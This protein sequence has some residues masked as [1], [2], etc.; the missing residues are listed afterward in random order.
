[1]SEG[2]GSEVR[3]IERREGERH[4]PF[5]APPARE[6]R[7]PEPAPLPP[8]GDPR[9]PRSWRGLAVVLALVVGLAVAL[10]V[11]FVE[12]IALLE[13]DDEPAATAQPQQVAVAEAP[14][15]FQ[16]TLRDRLPEVPDTLRP[17]SP[18]YDIVVDARVAGPYL[19]TLRLNAPTQDQRNLGAYTFGDS[20]WR[21][22]DSALLNEDGSAAQVELDTPPANIA[23]LRRLQFRDTVTGRVHQGA[24]LSPDAVNALTIINPEGFVPAEDGS[25]LGRVDQLPVGVTQPIYPVV[26]AQAEGAEIVNTVLASD[27]LRRQHINNILLM[28]QTGR[29]DGVDIDYQQVSPALRDAFTTFITELA[30]QL[31][32]DGRGLSVHVPLPR[33]DVSGLNEGAYDLAAL[34]AAADLIK[35]APLVDPSVFAETM[36][37][38]L[39]SVLD[40][41][42][43]EKV[44]LSLS[45]R[46][47]LRSA[48][49]FQQL[50]QRDAL[51]LAST[52]SIREPGPVVSGSRVTLVGDS[53]FQDGGASGLF[54]DQFARMVSFV[55]P[56]TGGNL[57]TVWIENRFSAA[58]KLQAVE[59]FRLGGLDIT[60]VSADGAQANL[61]TAVTIFLETG[62]AQPLRPNPALLTPFWEVDAGELTG[63]GSAGWVVWETPR[64]PG[65]YEARLILSD[66]D[67]RVGH[68]LAVTVEP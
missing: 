41:V 57:V 47:V 60:D 3:R 58:F 7:R 18:I 22:L 32:R 55:Y 50:S 46:S 10:V 64:L 40:R 68:G 1:M 25:L 34:G 63:S 4:S 43:R 27:Q 48:N 20:G 59:A 23:V 15:S 44:L 54:W 29:Y 49:G 45:P 12:P 31:H 65:E 19:F 51:G 42:P 52:L 33:R 66:G 5:E 8:T 56:D 62:S 53:I 38:T 9:A 61:W 11:L 36:E 6:R 35:I 26:F 28:V 21:R 24:E 67:V 37:S 16:V 39:P 17:V 30:D 2:P 14:G 13:Q